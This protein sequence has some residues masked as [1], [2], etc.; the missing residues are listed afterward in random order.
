[1]IFR[2]FEMTKSLYRIVHAN[3]QALANITHG[4]MS[5]PALVARQIELL[6]K[7][8]VGHAFAIV[9]DT[10]STITASPRESFV[11]LR[12][13]MPASWEGSAWIALHV[14]QPAAGACAR[15][16]GDR[17]VVRST[18]CSNLVARIRK[19]CQAGAL[20]SSGLG[21]VDGVAFI[22]GRQVPHANTDEYAAYER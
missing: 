9:R 4:F 15:S 16:R 18:G 6:M 20:K 19:G 5:D 7:P 12:N 21:R 10:S 22:G 14:M 11:H 13:S 1:M 8:C 2:I 3:P 17:G